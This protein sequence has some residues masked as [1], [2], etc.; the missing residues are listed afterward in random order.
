[1]RLGRH[2]PSIVARTTQ[3][4]DPINCPTT[5]RGTEFPSGGQPTAVEL[6]ASVNHRRS[7]HLDVVVLTPSNRKNTTRYADLVRDRSFLPRRPGGCHRDSA[8]AG[9]TGSGLARTALVD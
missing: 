3:S 9:A 1:M 4:G 8:G 6:T 5:S 2:I 7:G